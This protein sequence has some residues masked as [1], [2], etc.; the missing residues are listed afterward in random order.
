M[1]SGL[2]SFAKTLEQGALRAVPQPVRPYAL[3]LA[4]LAVLVCTTEVC[5]LVFGPRVPAVLSGLLVMAFLLLILG[6]AW[7]GYGPGILISAITVLAVP[8]L[9]PSPNRTLRG[10]L[11]RFSLGLAV[12][13]GCIG[14]RA[15]A[16]LDVGLHQ[17]GRAH[18]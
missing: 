3:S 13:G 12:G 8:R 17:I 15:R 18:V 7:L 9:R 2:R 5:Y 6:A 16:G 4:S 1:L 11:F 10:D 14:R